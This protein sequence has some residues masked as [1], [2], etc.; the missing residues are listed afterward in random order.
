MTNLSKA[1][2]NYK[3]L[4]L[5]PIQPG[6]KKPAVSWKQNQEEII[7]YSQ[8]QWEKAPAWAAVTGKVSGNFE[9]IDV[10]LKVLN[11]EWTQESTWMEFKDIVNSQ[12]P[13]LY[14]KITIQQT[15]NKGYH[16]FYR[17]IDTIIPSNHVLAKTDKREAL[18]ETRGEGGYVM[19]SPSDG[20][21]VVQG[22]LND[23]QNI[24]IEERQCLIGA[25]KKFNAYIEEQTI[26]IIE[27]SSSP[28][29]PWSH[30]NNEGDLVPVLEKHGWKVVDRQ[31]VKVCLERPGKNEGTQSATWNND[32]ERW[33]YVFSSNAQ[34]FEQEKAYRASQVFAMLECG[35][36]WSLTASK[37][38]SLGFVGTEQKTL[39]NKLSN[40]FQL[41]SG[42]NLGEDNIF[43]DAIYSV[44]RYK[45]T[46]KIEDIQLLTMDVWNS[47]KDMPTSISVLTKTNIFLLVANQGF[48]KSSIMSSIAAQAFVTNIDRTNVK[49][50]H[51]KLHDNVK[52]ILYIDSELKDIDA[53][54]HYKN[55]TRR[56][57]KGDDDNKTIELISNDRLTYAQI[58]ELLKS[59]P[60]IKFKATDI[61]EWFILNA[62]KENNPYDLV[63]LDDASC[64]VDHVPG[65]INNG[66]ECTT[67]SKWLNATAN[68]YNI[69]F[70]CTLHGNPN[71]VEGTGKGR[72]V[73][74]S[75][76]GRFCES[77]L[78]LSM[79]KK[80]E[81]YK[82][83]LGTIGKLRRGGI[84]QLHKNPLWYYYDEIEN[85]MMP[86]D[87]SFQPDCDEEKVINK[88]E[89]KKEKVERK[90]DI[91]ERINAD[92][93]S[94]LKQCESTDS[95][96]VKTIFDNYFPDYSRS[97]IDK[98][99]TEWKENND[100]I[101][102][103]Y[104]IKGHPDTIKIK[105][106]AKT[107]YV[108]VS[109]LV[110]P[111]TR[112]LPKPEPDEF[113]K[114]ILQSIDDK[115]EIDFDTWFND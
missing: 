58:M 6:S 10:D 27:R 104:T 22:D 25:A 94:I 69:G 56:L 40:T 17:C 107:V 110:I 79:S 115:D 81:L 49:N 65:T 28:T 76:L 8:T 70:I 67:A 29:S 55:M 51:F 82:I 48:G 99:Y 61:I 24:S 59:H 50:I 16:L 86:M 47:K 19:V 3:G 88:Q 18:F 63:I 52:R 66:D 4:S 87:C 100:D 57:G 44:E 89:K 38:K 97:T 92:I 11:D 84:F 45:N 103:I 15:R 101:F 85:L 90:N 32:G 64:L 108:P 60:Q 96:K 1:Y 31:G 114:G 42:N 95:K 9:C 26:E 71:D 36:D 106:I 7:E 91:V 68:T 14:A 75:E 77:S 83:I 23:I 21:S 30:Y 102:S 43:P 74:G 2:P 73:L 34:P 53:K 111:E 62:I 37:L 39:S 41:E 33:F 98:F 20:Y 35:N 112:S 105:A 72:G 5:I 46:P 13:E 93:K 54:I 80:D 12:M 109:D 78:N 113:E